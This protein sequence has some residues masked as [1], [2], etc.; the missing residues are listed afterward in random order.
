MIQLNVPIGRYLKGEETAEFVAA[1]LRRDR[2]QH[3]DRRHR[4]QQVPRGRP[5]PGT[6]PGALDLKYGWNSNELFDGGRILSHITCEGSSSK[7]C[8]PRSMR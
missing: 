4:V 5:I 6:E 1:Q 7:F 8:I 3:R 2:G